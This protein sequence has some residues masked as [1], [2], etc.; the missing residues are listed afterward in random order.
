[1]VESRFHAVD[2]E[3]CGSQLMEPFGVLSGVAERY[4]AIGRRGD[5][6]MPAAGL[7]CRELYRGP[8]EPAG[9]CAAARGCRPVTWVYSPHKQQDKSK[10]CSCV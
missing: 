1:M 10:E 7:L 4:R 6:A 3:G 8:I 2:L 9:R 5:H